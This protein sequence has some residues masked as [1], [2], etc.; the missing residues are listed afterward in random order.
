MQGSSK[1]ALILLTL[2][3]L[4]RHSD[5][6]HHLKQVELQRRI[7]EDYGQEVDRGSLRRYLEEL[8]RAGFPVEE[9]H[10]WYYA[11]PFHPSELNLI[12]D[13]LMYNPAVPWGQCRQLLAGLAALG[14]P[15][16]V[17]VA[18]EGAADARGGDFFFT[19]DVLHEA[20]AA[21]RKVTFRYGHYDVDKQ[22]H[23]SER[24]DG[25]VR[26]LAVSPYRVVQPNGRYYL[27]GNTDGH[28]GLSHYRIDR[29]MHIAP[30]EEAA[31]DA[32]TVEGGASLTDMP[33]YLA[34]H[35]HM[36]SG[37]PVTAR[38]RA[39]RRMAGDILDWFGMG[40]EFV[41]ATED[42]LEAEVRVDERS[43]GYWLRQYDEVER[44]K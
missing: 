7:L 32:L 14:G 27:I 19:L 33:R 29:I 11:H 23:P 44:I 3:A 26:T 9:D 40:T 25:S 24:A 20:I 31:R 8:R 37:M 42:T 34:E 38:L 18:R 30:S 41:R 10:G 39:P 21:G 12:A 16:Y 6:T 5:D 4:R 13:S 2:E 36:F 35:P 22:L 1:K 28:D 43:L 15:Y 17:P